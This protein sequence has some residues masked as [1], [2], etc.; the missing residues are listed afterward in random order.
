MN[1]DKI[2]QAKQ[3]K[4][5]FDEL[6]QTKPIVYKGTN[7]IYTPLADEV[8]LQCYDENEEERK[9]LPTIWFISQYDNLIS[10]RGN[11]LQILP[12]HPNKFGYLYYTYNSEK[13]G[14][15]RQIKAH[16]LTFL[17]HGSKR[18]GRAD[19]LLKEKGLDAFKANSKDT[20]QDHDFVQAHHKD[21]NKKNNK[22]ENGLIATIAV[23]KLL[24]KADQSQTEE[25]KIKF[26]QQMSNVLGKE[27]EDDVE[28]CFTILTTG[29]AWNDKGE[30]VPCN[31][32]IEDVIELNFSPT[33][34]AEFMACYKSL[35]EQWQK[36]QQQK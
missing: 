32:D 26:M 19:K 35:V 27:H 34:L 10:I 7:N 24:N 16:Q 2:E 20:S 9:D 14:Q 36:A 28:P 3:D 33:G 8:F 31:K 21:E 4:Q 12:K 18:Y 13:T 1:K 17:V 15:T 23:H 29:E 11:K 6:M 22:A 30:K 25:E 5:K